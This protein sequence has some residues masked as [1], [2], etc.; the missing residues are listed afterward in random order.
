MQ[1][2][3][4]NST[5]LS[6]GKKSSDNSIN[7]FSGLERK[8]LEY[9][10]HLLSFKPFNKYFEYKLT[11][12]LEKEKFNVKQ[13]YI[14]ELLPQLCM[15]DAPKLWGKFIYN[16]LSEKIVSNENDYLSV[17]YLV[18]D[19]EEFNSWIKQSIILY[20]EINLIKNNFAVSNMGL[21]VSTVKMTVNNKKVSIPFE[22]LVQEGYF[23]LLRAIEKFDYTKGL[24]FSTYSVW[25]IRHY[26]QRFIQDRDALIRVPTHTDEI[27]NRVREFK[28]NYQ[29]QYGTLPTDQEIVNGA[30][31]SSLSIATIVEPF[32]IINLDFLAPDESGLQIKY[33]GID[34]LQ[35]LID[36]KDTDVLLDAINTLTPIEK[37]IIYN[38]FGFNGEEMTLAE[39]GKQLDLS[40]ERVRQIQEKTLSKMKK[41]FARQTD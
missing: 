33:E 9:Y 10:F 13:K 16:L 19:T 6:V 23:G 31:I 2:K 11:E 28:Q 21:V 27:R 32:K 22:D 12:F 41:R 15:L 24:K 8:E 30:K 38:R 14:N 40:R 29:K 5:Q 36:K 1:I 17:Y 39:V 35:Y 3:L 37:K 26:V 18:R 20:M 34:A 25:W 7:I 4:N